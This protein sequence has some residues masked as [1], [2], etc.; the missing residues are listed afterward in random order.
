MKI[1]ILTAAFDGL[2]QHTY[3]EL[4]ERGHT[5][6]VQ[7]AGTDAAM[8]AAV[9]NYKPQLIIA[10]FL[11]KPVPASI[12]Q[13]YT[14]LCVRPGTSADRGPTTKRGAISEGW[15]DWRISITQAS[16]EKDAPE[17]WTSHTLKMRT[18]TKPS[19]YRHLFAQAAVQDILD[20]VEKLENKA[21]SFK[22]LH[23][24]PTQLRGRLHSSLL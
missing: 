13:Q 24:M 20:S 5:V 6:A 9:V 18:N 3:T 22:P 11:N 16:K 4:V 8:E 23:I 15:Q 17:I 2:S 10:P 1:L 14:V 21:F 12:T 19:Y 7:S